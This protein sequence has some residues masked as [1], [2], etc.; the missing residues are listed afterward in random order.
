MKLVADDKIPFL[1]GIPERFAQ[2]LYLP[3]KEF[4]YENIKDADILMVR[5][6][7][8]CTRELLEN[9]QV[10][11]IAS[12][13][14]GFDHIDT[15][16]CKE[17]GIKWT[18]APGCN[19]IS[20]AQY[21]L[22]SLIELSRLKGFQLRD[23]VLGI[24][25]VGNVG[26]QV[27]RV[28]RAYGITCLLYDP[29][30]A[31]QEGNG[32][33]ASMQEIAEQCDIL[34]FHVP[35]TYEGEQATY[36]MANDAFFSSLAKKPYFINASRGAVHDTPAL[37][38]AKR[39]GKIEEMIIDC[40]ESEPNISQELLSETLIASPHLA[41]FSADGKANGTRMCLEA[42]SKEFNIDIPDLNTLTQPA[43]PKDPVIDLNSFP[44]ER[45]ENAIL[46]TF[47]PLYEDQRLKGNPSL[48]EYL[49]THYDNPRE[50]A[51]YTVIHASPEEQSILKALGF[52]V[53][54]TI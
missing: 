10:K 12:T 51:A 37:L 22:S 8:K 30:R 42:I 41:G 28:C 27:E 53:N 36:H 2:V 14:I 38:R 25:G 54:Q 23:R 9:T 46:S 49:R 18:N 31:K 45:L 32:A 21:I 39:E 20:V 48:F 6:P 24:I 47:S 33:F 17:A 52:C 11:F 43:K 29:P 26:K 1:R 15:G 50:F 7:N 40:W 44:N 35:L 34:T 4:K 13:T 3:V 5:T 19:A 16:F